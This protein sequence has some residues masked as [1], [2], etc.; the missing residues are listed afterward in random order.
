MMRENQ[1]VMIHVLGDSINDSKSRHLTGGSHRKDDQH[2][3]TERPFRN[4]RLIG[5][6]SVL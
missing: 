1:T 3:C 5:V 2:T 4:L 6:F